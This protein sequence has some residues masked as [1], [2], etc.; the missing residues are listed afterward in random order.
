MRCP[1]SEGAPRWWSGTAIPTPRDV[2]GRGAGLSRGRARPAVR[3]PGGQAARLAAGGHRD[4]PR[5]RLRRQ[6]PEVP[7]A[8]QPRSAARGDPRPASRTCSARSRSS[9]PRWCAPWG[10]SPRSSSRAARMAS[11]G[12]TGTSCPCRSAGHPVLLYPLFHP[13]A[14]LYTRA[15]L[16]T[17]QEDFA[18]I[19]ELLSAE[20]LPA[21]PE[22]PDDLEAVPGRRPARHGPSPPTSSSASSDRPPLRERRAPGRPP[23]WAPPWPRCSSRATWCSCAASSGW[24][25]PPW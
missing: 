20:P 25:R 16:S 8:G 9:G 5:R 19:P 14:A 21:R 15:M 6:R 3:G 23:P 1:L 4:V 11:R 24:A 13:A 18:R 2:R 10:T 7:P 17:L 12:S 22:T